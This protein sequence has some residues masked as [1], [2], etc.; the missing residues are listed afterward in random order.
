MKESSVATDAVPEPVN[1]GMTSGLTAIDRARHGNAQSVRVLVISQ[2]DGGRITHTAAIVGYSVTVIELAQAA[3]ELDARHHHVAVVDLPS[4]GTSGKDALGILRETTPPTPALVVDLVDDLATADRWI[5]AGADEY[6]CL[7]QLGPSLLR[8]AVESAVSRSRAHELRR[9]LEHADRL[10][11]IGTLAAGVA[12]EVNNPASYVLMNLK[13]CRDHLGVLRERHP[14]LTADERALIDEMDEMLGDNVRGVERIVGI[15][16]AL[17]AY[18]RSDPDE[19]ERI[20][21]ASV[22][23]D[24]VDLVGNQL[25]QR[26]RLRIDLAQTAPLTADARKLGQVVINLLVN[27]Y[28]SLPLAASGHASHEIRLKLATSPG[29]IELSVSDTGVGI[30]GHLQA[31]IFEPFYTTKPRGE[32]AGLGLVIVRDI[33]ERFGGRVSVESEPGHGSQFTVVFPAEEQAAPVEVLAVAPAAPPRARVLII[34]DEVALTSAMR[35]QLRRSHEVTVLNDGTAAMEA[36]LEQEYD[37]ILCDLMM[38]GADGMAVLEAVSTRRPEMASRMVLMTAGIL[39]DT[40]RE[41]VHE[42]GGHVLDKP[43]PLDTLL[44]VIDAIRAR[45]RG[46]PIP[47][48][49]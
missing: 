18:A 4:L 36:I 49:A 16:H 25:R 22:C 33:V 8:G 30:P 45:S 31:R 32:G 6:L 21:L 40:I 15:V 3:H 39:Q 35:R 48:D 42:A 27:A 10:A 46:V 12:H 34:D 11:A 23:R 38:P 24:A 29:R 44:T 26:A 43:V 1:H 37:V 14:A 13:T 7:S 20:D 5:E 17:R 2:G 28:D 47:I 19:I 9:R 41:R